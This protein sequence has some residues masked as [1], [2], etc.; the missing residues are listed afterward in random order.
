MSKLKE[1]TT[2]SVNPNGNYDL[3]WMM[4]P[5]VHHLSQTYPMLDTEG[6]E[7]VYHVYEVGEERCLWELSIFHSTLLWT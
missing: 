4:I 1:C 7:A 6:E 2:Q 5:L 3:W